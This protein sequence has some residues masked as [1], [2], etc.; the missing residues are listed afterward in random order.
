MFKATLNTNVLQSSIKA[1]SAFIDETRL[2][3]TPDRISATA[4][5]AAD[6]G[7][8]SINI[9]STECVFFDA[10]DAE[11]G[12]DLTRFNEILGMANKSNEITLDLDENTHKLG[13]A[14]DGFVYTMALLDPQTLRKAPAIPQLDLPAEITIEGSAFKRMVKAASMMGDHMMMGVQD[15]TFFMDASGDSDKVR[16]DL[17]GSEL[18]GL[19]S[20]DVSA[21]YSVEYLMDMSKAIGAANEV[22]IHLGRV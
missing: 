20:A 1:L 7:M 2:V 6:A 16:L 4:V 17:S 22:V 19:K 3:V 21:L 8:T 5:D 18:I 11:L 15:E 14:F 12:I 13:I 9:P 10:T